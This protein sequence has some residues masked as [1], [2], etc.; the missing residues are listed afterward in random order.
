FRAHYTDD[1]RPDSLHE[2]SR[3]ARHDG[4]WVYTTAVF[5]D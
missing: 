3:F 4:A 5:V 2:K 1:G